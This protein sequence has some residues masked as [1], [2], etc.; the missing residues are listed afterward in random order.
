MATPIVIIIY[1][2]GQGYKH[3][4][5]FS[6]NSNVTGNRLAEKVYDYLGLPHYSA[7]SDFIMNGEQYM[8]NEMQTRTSELSKSL[9]EQGI[10]LAIRSNGGISHF[11]PLSNDKHIVT[12]SEDYEPNF[13][14]A[15]A[16]HIV[17]P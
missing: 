8:L 15:F 7:R 14:S 17:L 12:E 13:E 1:K 10:W 9:R 11:C 6:S 3:Y 5:A 4:T 2:D 16:N